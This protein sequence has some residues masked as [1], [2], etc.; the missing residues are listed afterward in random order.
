MGVDVYAGHR[1]GAYT[2]IA[3]TRAGAALAPTIRSGK[4]ATVNPLA[5][6]AARLNSR[7]ICE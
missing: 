2:T 4:Q 5:G 6:N 3:T 1:L 7:S